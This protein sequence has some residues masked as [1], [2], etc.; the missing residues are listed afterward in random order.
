MIPIAKIFTVTRNETDLIE[1]FILYHGR[2]F[3]FSNIIII[4][5]MSTCPIV[6][7]VYREY[8]KRGVTVVYESINN[9]IKHGNAY[10]KYMRRYIRKTQFLIGLDSDEFI[11]IHGQANTINDIESYLKSIP[12]ETSVIKVP[13]YLSS[14]PDVKSDFYINQKINNPAINIITFN[15]ERVSPQKC[16]Y[17]SCNFISAINSCNG[18]KVNGGDVHVSKRFVYLHFHN[19]GGRR[20]MEKA[21]EVINCYNYTDTSKPILNQFE[22]LLNKDVDIENKRV[23]EYGLFLSK[24]LCLNYIIRKSKWPTIQELCEVSK[25]IDVIS[26][27]DDIDVSKMKSLPLDWESRYEEILLK[28]ILS[29]EETK[30][31]T[32]INTSLL[33]CSYP[34]YNFK[35]KPLKKI[36][37]LL[38]GHLR[39]FSLRSGFWTE[40]N[41][42]FGNRVDI[43]VH[44]WN[45]TGVRSKTQWIDIGKDTPNFEEVKRALNPRKMMI[46]NH[47]EKISSFSLK[48]PGLKLYYTNGAY[49]SKTNDFTRNIGSQLYSIMKAWELANESNIEYDMMIR[50]RNDCVIKNFENVFN[51]DTSFLQKDVLIVNGNSHKHPHGGGGCNKCNI[52]YPLRRHTEHSND[53]CDIMYLA[54]PKVMGRVCN[55]FNDAKKLILSFKKYNELAIKDKEVKNAL[56]EYPGIYGIRNPKIYETRVK[57]FYPERLIREY[58]NKT[59]ILSDMMGLLVQEKYKVQ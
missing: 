26:K 46:E 14:V 40:F 45:E 24:M 12:P 47:S 28:D 49:L 56:I 48:S 43:Y 11:Y 34:I 17:R 13:T 8:I 4:D 2:L 42:R 58:M 31:K 33:E 53:V 25:K 1:S 37:L 10:T 55:M 18:C 23:L 20:S 9:G 19:T 41:R 44:T 38:S 16:I 59:W 51:R 36:A 30:V 7:G 6:K 54:N 5:N 52:E 21:L 50:M 35:T 22:S 3:G 15:V 29:I 32:C 57:C 39:N 27:I